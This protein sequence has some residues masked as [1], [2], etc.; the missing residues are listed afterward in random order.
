MISFPLVAGV[1][2]FGAAGAAGCATARP[3]P[4]PAVMRTVPPP[5]DAPRD[6]IANIEAAGMRQEPLDVTTNQRI[7]RLTVTLDGTPVPVPAWIGV[8]RLRAVQAAAHT[9]EPTGEVWLEGTEATVATLGQFFTLWGVAFDATRLGPATGSVR[10][11]A[12]GVAVADPVGLVLARTRTVQ[13]T[14]TT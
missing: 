11:M 9:H 5:W 10:V 1:S 13:V 8:D 12:D 4:A 14:A 3:A 2:L 6:A 7:T